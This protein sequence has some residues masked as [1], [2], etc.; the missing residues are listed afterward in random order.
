MEH[1]E[2]LAE[3][4]CEVCGIDI[5]D[6]RA[7]AVTCS[8]KCRKALHNKRSL[9]QNGTETGTLTMADPEHLDIWFE[10]YTIS[11]T[12]GLGRKKDEKSKVRKARYW[13]DVP[14]AAIPVIKKGNPEMPELMNGRQYFLWWKNDFKMSEKFPD[15]PEI[16]NPRPIRENLT[17]VQAGDNSRR[18]GA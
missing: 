14:I 1:I 8:P 16:H 12:N 2:H 4:K 17:Y 15:S 13:Y 6:K 18:W 10:F 7:S 3:R 11:R 9:E 5:T